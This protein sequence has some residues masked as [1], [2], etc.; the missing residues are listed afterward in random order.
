MLKNIRLV[1]MGSAFAMI[2]CGALVACGTKGPLYIPEQ[3]Y[4]QKESSQ[5]E[6]QKSVPQ[7]A[8]IKANPEANTNE[9]PQ[10]AQ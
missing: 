6:V 3:R 1:I 5:E 4:P 7:D 9:P 8:D 10:P 2:G